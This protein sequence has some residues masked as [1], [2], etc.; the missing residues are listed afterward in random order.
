[1]PDDID[2]SVALEER[3]HAL[4]LEQLKA[5]AQLQ[6]MPAPVGTCYNPRCGDDLPE[7][8]SFCGAAC[9]DEWEKFKKQR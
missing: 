9:R 4:N 7:G 2:A 1:M 8:R 6:K 5:R 3:F